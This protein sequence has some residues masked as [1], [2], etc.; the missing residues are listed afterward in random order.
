[1]ISCNFRQFHDIFIV[2]HAHS[3]S[4]SFKRYA[5]NL[6]LYFDKVGKD[7]PT[8]LLKN[9]FEECIKLENYFF[10]KNANLKFFFDN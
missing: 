7:F 9:N 5:P 10:Q 1:M 3:I 6:K 4:N 2:I 8:R